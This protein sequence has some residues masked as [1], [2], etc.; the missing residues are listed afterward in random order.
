MEPCQFQGMGAQRGV[1]DVFD[2]VGVLLIT[3]WRL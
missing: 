2:R 1:L 3:G